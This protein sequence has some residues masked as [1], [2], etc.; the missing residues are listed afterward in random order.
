MIRRISREHLDSSSPDVGISRC[1]GP[2]EL[3]APS[4]Q[5]HWGLLQSAGDLV[6]GRA[7]TYR[8]EATTTDHDSGAERRTGVYIGDT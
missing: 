3:H 4:E 2:Q 8:I 7:I 6:N 5:M 1:S